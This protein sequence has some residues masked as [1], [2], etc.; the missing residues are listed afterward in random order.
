MPTIAIIIIVNKCGLLLQRQAKPN[1]SG[2]LYEPIDLVFI[3]ENRINRV[4]TIKENVLGDF[5]N[6]YT[7]S[8]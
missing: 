5:S 8:H 4:N 1:H 6:E 7:K 3:F 2:S